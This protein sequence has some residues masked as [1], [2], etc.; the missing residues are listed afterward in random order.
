M[1]YLGLWLSVM[2]RGG[3]SGRLPLRSWDDYLMGVF[4][5]F[6]KSLSLCDFH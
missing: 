3:L 6:K 5:K 4:P 1:I 2:D